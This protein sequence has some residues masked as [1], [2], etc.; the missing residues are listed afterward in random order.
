MVDLGVRRHQLDVRRRVRIAEVTLRHRP[1]HAPECASALLNAIPVPVIQRGSEKSKVTAA[2]STG[3]VT[4]R[5]SESRQ[6]VA[7]IPRD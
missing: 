4:A 5:D 1:G 3:G 6:R 2:S 7:P